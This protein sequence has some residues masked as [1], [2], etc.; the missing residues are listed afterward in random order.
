MK[1]VVK[2][3]KRG[4]LFWKT[5]SNVKA[6]GIYLNKEEKYDA[7]GNLIERKEHMTSFR[8][9]ILEDETR[10]EICMEGMEFRFSP[11]RFIAIKKS[12]ETQAGQ[13]IPTL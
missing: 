7:N 9:F 3:R 10:I 5:L 12:M 11:E 13:N 8:W 2:F 6:D 1:Y 4:S